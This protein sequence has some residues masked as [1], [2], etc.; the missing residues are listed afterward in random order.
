MCGAHS[1]QRMGLQFTTA[2]GTCHR[3]HSRVLVS[4]DSWPILLSQIRDLPNLEDQVPMFIPPQEQGPQLYSQAVGSHF[5]TSYDS[6]GYLRWRYSTHLHMELIPLPLLVVNMLQN[7]VYVIVLLLC[8][9]KV[10]NHLQLSVEAI[11]NIGSTV[12][13]Y[14]LFKRTDPQVSWIIFCCT[15][16]ILFQCHWECSLFILPLLWIKFSKEPLTCHAI[17][18]ASSVCTVAT[19]WNCYYICTLF[20]CTVSVWE[21]IR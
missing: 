4:Q 8:L 18:A 16:F 5:V 11:F 6:Q 9:I 2:A 13:N 12:G 10:C 3:S 1:V 19:K 21:L 17:R 15:V 7:A 20:N 14:N